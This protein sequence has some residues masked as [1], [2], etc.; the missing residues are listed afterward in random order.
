M[1]QI[2]PEFRDLI[3]PLA[4]DDR[5]QL[6][7]NIMRDGCRDPLVVWKG[8]NLLVDGH[9]RF[10]IC[11]DNALEFATVEMEFV[12]REAVKEWIIT[13]QLGRR[14]LTRQQADYLRGKKLELAKQRHGGQMP[15]K[16]MGQPAPS[17]STAEK[18]AR[19]TGVSSDTVKR[20]QRFSQAVD[21]L[22]AAG[23][24][25]VKA[26]LLSGKAKMSNSAAPAVQRLTTKQKKSVAE[27]VASGRAKSVDQA[28]RETAPAA[29]KPAPKK[30]SGISA[31]LWTEI[32]AAAG[33]LHRLLDFP[34]LQ[35]SIFEARKK[36][37]E[38][39][40]MV[41]GVNFAADER[42]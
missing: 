33:E 17:L 6:L 35:V 23:G 14:T 34:P 36:A 3:P 10:E 12:D 29:M 9:N 11:A 20:N 16:G 40:E 38:L 8:K 30:A 18:V 15:R 22:A 24:P 42:T 39:L 2:D 25:E 5:A 41:S 13:N 1:I 28:I 7:A 32:V 37:K 27:K 19:D 4:E 21:V 26:A 31:E